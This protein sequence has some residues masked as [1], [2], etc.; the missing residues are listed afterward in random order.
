MDYFG[1]EKG[2]VGFYSD[3]VFTKLG[4]GAGQTAYRNPIAGL[5]VSATASAALTTQIAIIEMGGVCELY[6][7][8]G[9]ERSF[10]AVDAVGGFRYWNLSVDATLDAQVNVDLSRLHLERTA[11]FAIAPVLAVQWSLDVT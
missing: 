4:F 11:G 6:R 10:T 5:E 1:A 2:R 9:S 3:L 7:W 8:P